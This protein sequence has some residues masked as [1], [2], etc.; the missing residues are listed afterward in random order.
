MNKS[1]SHKD[2]EIL[3]ELAPKKVGPESVCH[4]MKARLCLMNK[5][6]VDANGI[7]A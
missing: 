5:G 7:T 3:K 1:L 2:F 4:D 6:L